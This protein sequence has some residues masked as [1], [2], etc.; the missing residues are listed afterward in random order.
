MILKT[1]ER[2]GAYEAK[3]NYTYSLFAQKVLDC[4]GL[5]CY[6]S[7]NINIKKVQHKNQKVLLKVNLYCT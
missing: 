1:S 2:I 7:L 4:A 6:N 3:I 5:K